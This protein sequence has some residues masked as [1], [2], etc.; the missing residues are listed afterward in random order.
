MK[1]FV[2]I[3]FSLFTL[4]VFF[5]LPGVSPSASEISVNVGGEAFPGF[6]EENVSYAPLRRLAAACSDGGAEIKWEPLTRSAEVTAGKV[7]FTATAGKDTVLICG[8]E[9]S[10]CGTAVIHNSVMY[11]PVRSVAGLL[12]YAASWDGLTR[13][14][15]L[16]KSGDAYYD[17]YWL[18]RIIS[19]ESR[20]EPFEGQIAV[21]NVI[22]ERVKSSEFPNSIYGVIFD[23]DPTIQ[24]TPVENGTVYDD[25]E[26]SCIEAAKLCLE[27]QT[28]VEDCLFFQNPDTTRSTWVA[29]N[30][31]FAVR[32]GNHC[33]YK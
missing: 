9:V 26:E 31:E 11:V 23:I 12:G 20:G 2:F 33:F 28:A 1:R 25:P 10:L 19:A 4:L 3:L 5:L 6:I 17:L 30:R 13:S 32:I 27:G 29:D 24:F 8:N 7:T 22:L 14:V 15:N 21:G 16:E 18:S